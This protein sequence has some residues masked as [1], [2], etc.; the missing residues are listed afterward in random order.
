MAVLTSQQ[1]NALETAV[2]NARSAAEQ[3]AF[4]ALHSLGVDSTEPFPHL[5]AD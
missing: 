2:K 4:N 5:T 3:G 1:R